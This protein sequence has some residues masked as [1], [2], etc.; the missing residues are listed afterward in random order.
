MA[1]T[2][3]SFNIRFSIGQKVVKHRIIPENN[4][5][6]APSQAIRS[7]ASICSSFINNSSYT[8]IT[9]KRNYAQI[10]RKLPSIGLGALTKLISFK[11]DFPI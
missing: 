3:S 11:L 4:I 10:H 7:Y 9:D 1:K 8:N 2:A 5:P 6:H